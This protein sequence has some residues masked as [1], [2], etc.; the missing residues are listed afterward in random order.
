MGFFGVEE[1]VGLGLV[2]DSECFRLFFGFGRWSFLCWLVRIGYVGIVRRVGG[3][4]LGL[5]GF[6]VFLRLFFW[7]GD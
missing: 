6:L 7:V 1:V 4:G 5:V 2:G 3:M